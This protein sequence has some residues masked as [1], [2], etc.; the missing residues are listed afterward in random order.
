MIDD[1]WQILKKKWYGTL[2]DLEARSMSIGS[3]PSSV[4]VRESYV[5]RSTVS[6]YEQCHHNVQLGLSYL[7]SLAL[8][9]TYFPIFTIT[10]AKSS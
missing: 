4:L 8:V 3:S 5:K 10:N 7:V 9:R 6:G 2:Q 1:S